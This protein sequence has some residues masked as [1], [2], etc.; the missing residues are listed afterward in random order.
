MPQLV[1]SA[2][3][4]IFSAKV[5]AVPSAP[6]GPIALDRLAMVGCFAAFPFSFLAYFSLCLS[7][8]ELEFLRL[9]VSSFRRLHYFTTSNPWRLHNSIMNLVLLCLDFH[10]HRR[11]AAPCVFVVV[12]LL[13]FC[14]SFAPVLLLPGSPVSVRSFFMFLCSLFILLAWL[15][16]LLLGHE[17]LLV[18]CVA[19]LFLGCL[20]SAVYKDLP[21]ISR[22]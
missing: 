14:L 12:S 9:F 8:C 11:I 3:T 17:L 13:L 22:S 6:L 4:T 15:Y 20:F 21:R 1:R 5:S 10:F 2:V 18:R 7:L 19:L 16:H